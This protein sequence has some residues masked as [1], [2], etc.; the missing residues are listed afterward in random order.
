M[1]D[2]IWRDIFF[3]DKQ[4]A[5]IARRYPAISVAEVE[6]AAAFYGQIFANKI[7][8]AAVRKEIDKITDQ[9]ITLKNSL[10]DIGE[11][12]DCLIDT[13]A[14]KMGNYNTRR[15]TI[16]HLDKLLRITHQAYIDSP[17]PKRGRTS[18]NTISLVAQ[19]ASIVERAGFNDPGHVAPLL[20]ICLEGVGEID[21]SGRD[22]ETGKLVDINGLVRRGLAARS[23][24]KMGKKN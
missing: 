4:R 22:T 12:T 19:L 23:A 1:S 18:A 20:Q 3:N 11:G 14:L 6:A 15:E 8:H 24:H 21:S 10:Y 16:A 9:I 5:E 17:A 2:G 7:S 13:A